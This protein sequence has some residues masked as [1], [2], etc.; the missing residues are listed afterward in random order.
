M[1]EDLAESIAIRLVNRRLTESAERL[2]LDLL[3]SQARVTSNK[4][5]ELISLDWLASKFT[6]HYLYLNKSSLTCSRL[7]LVIYCN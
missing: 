6:L 7:F 4:R 1:A 2:R 5:G 3:R